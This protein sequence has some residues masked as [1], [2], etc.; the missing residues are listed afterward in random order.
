LELAG[1]KFQI[2]VLQAA[3]ANRNGES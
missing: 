3:I 1:L 2:S